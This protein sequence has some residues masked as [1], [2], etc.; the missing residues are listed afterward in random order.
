MKI[1]P[2]KGSTMVLVGA[3]ALVIGT[4]TVREASAESQPHMR[5][6]LAQLEGAHA[7]L[8]KATADKGGHRRKAM[9]L[10]DAAIAEVEKGIEFKD[11]TRK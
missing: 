10:V 4:S 11:V 6:A 7:A 9:E 8:Q 2:W 3:L 1:N 5:A